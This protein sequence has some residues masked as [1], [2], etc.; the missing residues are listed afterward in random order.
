MDRAHPMKFELLHKDY[1]L[2]VIGGGIGGTIA[3]VT[4]ARRGL[5]TALVENKAGLGGN[6][7]S[8][9][10]VNFE[11]SSCLNYMPDIREGGPLEEV[12][13]LIASMDPELTTVH[14]SVALLFWCMAEKNLEVFLETTIDEVEVEDGRILSVSGTQAQ[15]EQRFHL[16]AGQFVDA[17]GDGTVAFLAGASF[18]FGRESRA[19]YG[20]ILAPSKAD[21]GIMGASILFRA[22]PHDKP[23]PFVKPAWAYTYTSD[24]DLPF[25]LKTHKGPVRSGFWWV[26][27]AGENNDTI[28]DFDAIRL[29]LLKCTYGVWAYLKQDPQRGMQNYMMDFIGITPGK[30]ESRRIIGDYV[31]T[32]HDIR[33]VT[34]FEDSVAYCGWNIDVHVPGG[35][36][37]K[38]YPNI[39]C[40]FPWVF[41]LPLRC[42]YAK[43]LRNLWLV[44]RDISTTHVAM[45]ATRLMGTIGLMGHAVG[46]AAAWAKKLNL[47][48]RETSLD[49]FR[50]IQQDILKDGA[51]IPGVRNEDANDHA[52]QAAVTAS[53]HYSLRLER[54]NEYAKIAGGRA[55]AFPLTSGRLE[56]VSLE[57]LNEGSDGNTV[58]LAL[59]RIANPNLFST[60]NTLAQKEVTLGAGKN[61]VCWEPRLANLEPGLYALFVRGE[62]VQC[63]LAADCPCGVYSAEYSPEK[64]RL[65]EPDM[66]SLSDDFQLAL[67]GTQCAGY[68]LTPDYQAFEWPRIRHFRGAPEWT[69][70][71]PMDRSRLKPICVEFEPAPHCYAGAEATNGV[72][73]ND[74]VPNLWISDPR[75]V[76]PQS[77]VLS[78]P[79]PRTIQEVRL[80]FDTDLDMPHPSPQPVDYMISDYSLWY[81]DGPDWIRIL[82]CRDQ[83]ARFSVH[84]FAP[85]RTASLRLQVESVHD[86]GKSARLYEIRAY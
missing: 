31:L 4:A 1:D 62:Q 25:R 79:E 36:K 14:T 28:K 38:G 9:I 3:A 64:Y 13:E 40:Y 11:G 61:T 76:M 63:L 73:H 12:K 23:A 21:S 32:E 85:I 19:D 52:R 18:M 5:K 42:L 84:T 46:V 72:S 66:P 86:A 34:Q 47:S 50:S 10:G 33:D 77:L 70:Y 54:S 53:S 16:R 6:G 22:S 82:E 65:I 55:V 56:N 78:W 29:E 48:C 49:H 57:L 51:W 20:E 41:N 45:G 26:E 58:T 37:S 2:V 7:G 68:M 8:A 17:S 80:V 75:A 74:I 35:F 27:F 30:R 43:D 60:R 15:T 39:H 24:D 71:W 59:A 67:E 83:R 44:G 69:C 81:L